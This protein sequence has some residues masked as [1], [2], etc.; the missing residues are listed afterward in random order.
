MENGQVTSHINY[1]I[2][3][4]RS[5][6]Y[7]TIDKPQ[8][9]MYKAKQLKILACYVKLCSNC[10]KKSFKFIKTIKDWNDTI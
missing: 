5:Y 4:V 6:E 10:S 2:V 8:F 1:A 3:I 7:K 9:S